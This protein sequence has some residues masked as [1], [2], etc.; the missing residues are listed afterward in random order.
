M[1]I[2]HHFVV[3][4]TGSIAHWF[5]PLYFNRFTAFLGEFCFWIFRIDVLLWYILSL[6][7]WCEMD[8][9][10]VCMSK[11]GRACIV[12][13]GTYSEPRIPCVECRKWMGG[14]TIF[15]T[16]RSMVSTQPFRL[17]LPAPR[18]RQSDYS[19]AVVPTV[20]RS[21]GSVLTQP[22]CSLHHVQF[23]ILMQSM[24]LQFRERE[25]SH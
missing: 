5:V 20:Q 22:V 13:N 10:G 7:A 17:E 8:Y 18:S 12:E 25:D 3:P 23:L 21:N 15:S 1:G 4:G 19:T 14:S 9:C 24:L 16:V 2:R 11:G 6:Q